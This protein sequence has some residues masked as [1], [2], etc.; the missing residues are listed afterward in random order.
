M[1]P[2]PEAELAVATGAEDAL[3]EDSAAML[4]DSATT[5]VLMTVLEA[6]ERLVLVGTTAR[7]DALVVAAAVVPVSIAVESKNPRVVEADAC[8]STIN[9]SQLSIV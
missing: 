4:L 8:C 3:F 7:L 1:T 6:R 5:E 9:V 2:T